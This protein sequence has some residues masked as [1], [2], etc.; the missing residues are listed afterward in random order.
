MKKIITF[1]VGIM[2]LNQEEMVASQDIDNRKYFSLDVISYEDFINNDPETLAILKE[3][4]YEKGIVGMKGVP[5]YSD[6]VRSF[7]QSAKE[8]TSLSEEKKMNYAPNHNN[9]DMFLGYEAGKERFKGPKGEWIVDDLKV[10]YYAFI[11]DKK[12]NKWPVEVDLKKPFQ[13][14][15]SL[16]KEIGQEVMIKIGLIGANTNILKI[17]DYSVGRMLYYRKDN[18]RASK[19]P[20][21]CGAHYDHGLFTALIPAYYFSD[22][23][24]I[25][26]PEEA[27]LFVKAHN[28]KEFQKV[29]SNDREILLFQVG[30]FG[31]L[32][33]NDLIRATEHRVNKAHE[34][35]ERYSL[36]VFFDVPME[37]I[38]HS[39]SILT[40]DERYGGKGGEPCSYEQWSERSF[41]RYHVNEN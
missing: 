39:S 1:L 21:W 29:S 15:G 23:N 36:A 26:E 24:E 41:K 27:G 7:I 34:D 6:K 9:G 11:P 33:T 40:Q 14:L 3:A 12:E 4:L 8:F 30:E 22:G 37:T 20:L 25:C 38:I 17:A 18:E 35:V 19:N 13:E 28:Q 31:Q 10:S 32:A 16:M 5:N 2:L